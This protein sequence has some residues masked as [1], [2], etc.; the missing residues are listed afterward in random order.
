MR[1]SGASLKLKALL[2]QSVHP[3]PA[4]GPKGLG[5][6]AAVSSLDAN[7]VKKIY[8]NQGGLCISETPKILLARK[9]S[10]GLEMNFGS[11]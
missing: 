9:G 6:K 2:P 1:S 8:E 4:N 11:R 10:E 3:L 7:A 5:A